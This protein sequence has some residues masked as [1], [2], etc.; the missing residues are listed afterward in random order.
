MPIPPPPPPRRPV[1][2]PPGKPRIPQ[3]PVCPPMPLRGFVTPFGGPASGIS[4]AGGLPAQAA[5]P[6][7]TPSPTPT[8]PPACVT[9]DKFADC[10]ATCTGTINFGSSGPLCGWTYKGQPVGNNVT[11]T[12][13]QMMVNVTSAHQRSGATKPLDSSLATV[14]STTSQF[15]FQEFSTPL[16]AGSFYEFYVTDVTNTTSIYVYLDDTG[17]AFVQAGTTVA[18]QSYTGVWTPNNGAHT[19]HL[20]VDGAGVPTL[21]IDGALIALTPGGIFPSSAVGLPGD[22]VWI[23]VDDFTG[24]AGATYTQIAVTTGVLPASTTFCCP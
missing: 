2:T 16:G 11:F 24:A 22:L 10:F 17:F 5:V 20:T 7:V 13:G 21:S 12:P 4:P 18:A 23:S 19:V 8:P 15:R 14:L 9:A 3:V 6:G 1:C